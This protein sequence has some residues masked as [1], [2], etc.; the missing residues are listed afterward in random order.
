MRLQALTNE[1]VQEAIAIYQRLAYTANRPAKPLQVPEGAQGEALLAGFQREQVESLP[2]HACCRFSL[3]LGNRNYPF[4]KLLL[5]EHLVPG[6]FY[7]GVDTH[8]Q[9]DIKPDYP[10]YQQWVAV[11]RFNRELKQRIE[12]EFA[13][14]GLDTCAV[15]RRALLAKGR[16][17]APWR[18]LALVVDDEVGL[19]DAAEV[20]LGRLGYRTC[21][22]YDGLAGLRAAQQLQPDLILADYEM[23]ELD[24][25]QL[26]ARLKADAATARIPFLLN[27]SARVSLEEIRQADGFLAKPYPESLLAEMIDRVTRNRQVPQ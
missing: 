1:V 16:G 2:G 26:L 18:G 7:F 15:V 12:A 3:R 4:M 23:P 24:G 9:M 8:D 13:A 10:D 25:L 5:Q 21:A 20:A 27:S 6:E 14:A 17:G 19:A 11:Q 22:A